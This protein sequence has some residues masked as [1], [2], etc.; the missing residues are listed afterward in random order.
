M[1]EVLQCFFLSPKLWN[2]FSVKKR[3]VF[4]MPVNWKMISRFILDMTWGHRTRSESRPDVSSPPLAHLQVFN[5]TYLALT[6]L[7]HKVLSAKSDHNAT[8]WLGVETRCSKR[9]VVWSKNLRANYDIYIYIYI[10][11]FF[12]KGLQ[13]LVSDSAYLGVGMHLINF[14]PRKIVPVVHCVVRSIIDRLER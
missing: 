4:S 9:A 1:R 6:A 8:Q 14:C 13:R 12:L 5:A 11:F 10:Y 2:D 3:A 7:Q